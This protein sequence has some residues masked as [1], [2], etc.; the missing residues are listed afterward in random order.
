MVLRKQIHVA[1]AAEPAE[2][3]PEKIWNRFQIAPTPAEATL[4]AVF[5]LC[6]DFPYRKQFLSGRLLGQPRCRGA[7]EEKGGVL[8]Y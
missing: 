2:R 3:I 7:A 5:S 6:L 4:C 8:D 1:T